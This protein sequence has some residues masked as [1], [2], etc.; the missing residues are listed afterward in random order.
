ML[1]VALHFLDTSTNNLHLKCGMLTPTLLD[2][3]DS[4]EL[5][6]TFDF[7]RGTFGNYIIDH[8]NTDTEEVSNEKHIAFLT[9]RL[10][11]YV[12]CSRSIQVAKHYKTLAYQLH[13]G[14]Q[15]CVTPFSARKCGPVWFTREFPAKNTEYEEETNA[16]WKAYLTPMLLSSRATSNTSSDYFGVDGYQPNL[17]ARLFG[18]VQVQ[19]CSFYQCK[20]DLKKTKTEPQWRTL[21][22]K[23]NDNF[24]NFNLLHF[25][26]SYECTKS[27]FIWWRGYFEKK[28]KK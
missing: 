24:P 28:A 21:L 7:K 6:I 23:L 8:Y 10:S 12:F 17:V 19:P 13:E 27:F 26:L 22:Q 15:V 16:I 5:D 11:M 25:E 20:E 14:K 2:V 3:A 18:F 4:C 1:L 9:F